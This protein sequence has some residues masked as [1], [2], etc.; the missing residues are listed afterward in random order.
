MPDNDDEL[1]AESGERLKRLRERSGLSYIEV[2][3]HIGIHFTTLYDYEGGRSSPTILVAARLALLFDCEIDEL[4][5]TQLLP[6]AKR[7]KRQ[8]KA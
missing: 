6:V 1:K 5:P 8:R 3:H 4:V 2:S 7:R